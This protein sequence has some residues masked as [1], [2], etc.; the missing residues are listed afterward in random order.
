LLQVLFAPASCLISFFELRGFEC[1]SLS[2]VAHPIS[3]LL[4]RSQ[5]SAGVMG[6]HCC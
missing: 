2:G 5:E 1:D 6:D 3:E 4:P